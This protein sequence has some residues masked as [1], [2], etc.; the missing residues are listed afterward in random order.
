M[1]LLPDEFEGRVIIT[2]PAPIGGIVNGLTTAV[3]DADTGEPIVSALDCTV[4]IRLD[5]P[6]VA[7]MT[8][9]TG[10][11]G[12]PLRQGETI[13]PL[14]SEDDWRKG[15]FRWLVTEIRHAEA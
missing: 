4:H 1:A 10:L 15:T 3:T 8:M 7:E 12:K 11:D 13:P 14:E 6:V 2:L 9:L 5:G